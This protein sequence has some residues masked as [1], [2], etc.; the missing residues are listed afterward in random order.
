MSLSSV[1][2]E[3]SLVSPGPVLVEVFLVR[4]VSKDDVA[5]WLSALGPTVVVVVD[6]ARGHSGEV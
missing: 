4:V 6:A 2:S 3:L 5:S 1:S